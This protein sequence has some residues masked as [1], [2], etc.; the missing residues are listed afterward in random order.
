MPYPTD[1]LKVTYG[2]KAEGVEVADTGFHIGATSGTPAALFAEIT[3]GVLADMAT[4]YYSNLMDNSDIKWADYSEMTTVK[5]ALV[6]TSGHYVGDP[7]VLDTGILHQGDDYDVLPQASVLISLWSGNHVGQANYG[8][9]YLPH[10]TQSLT[11]GHATVGTSQQT[12]MSAHAAAFVNA[13]N[14][15]LIGLA[16]G[17][18]GEVI[19]ISKKGAGIKKKVLYVRVGEIVDTQRRRYNRLPPNYYVTA[20]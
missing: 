18:V 8:R 3:T 4:A 20:L 9:M 14:A 12:N 19:N 7:V 13:I 6:D 10:T 2:F 11:H 1:F 5:C 17:A 16:P 15:I